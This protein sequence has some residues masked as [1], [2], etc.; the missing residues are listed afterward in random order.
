VTLPAIFI[1]CLKV[2]LYGIGGGGGL[3]W[4]RRIAVEQQHWISDQDFANIV[5]LCHSTYR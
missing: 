3:V 5:S 4:A 1:A 2:S